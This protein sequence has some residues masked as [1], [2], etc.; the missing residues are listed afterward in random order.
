M[1]AR[2]TID[3]PKCAITR[4]CYHDPQ[5]QR[6]YA[7]CAEGYG[8]LINALPPREP[9]KKGIVESGVTYVKANFCP[10]REFRSLGDANRQL[11]EW[12]MGTA[13]NRTHGTIHEKPLTR[14]A[15]TEQHLLRPVP[16]SP[17][18]LACW[19]RVKVHGDCHVQHQKC[20]YSVPYQLVGQSLWLRASETTTGVYQDQEMVAIH[21]RLGQP[22]QRSTLPEHLPP[23][24]LAYRMQDPQW[25]LRQ[26]KAI[27]PACHALIEQ[28]CA[29]RVLDTLRGAQGIVSFRTR[30][31]TSRVEAASARALAY[32]SPHDRTI[33]TILENGL[34][35]QPLDQASF[36][37]LGEA[38]TG[39]GRFSRDIRT[40]LTHQQTR[41]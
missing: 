9:Q 1:P 5:V 24:A 13:G 8:F 28:L 6:A 30:S 7:D 12:V 18:E 14:F 21:P 32:A 36:D 10:L 41:G 29:D 11:A 35:Q 34:D 39:R 22:G 26:A 23:H 20:R 16:A 2:V 27:G 3:N 25:C 37:Q 19:A 33:K 31:G 15:E 4:A 17:P 40:V 38:Y